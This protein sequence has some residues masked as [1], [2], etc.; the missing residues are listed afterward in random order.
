MGM[1][2]TEMGLKIQYERSSQGLITRREAKISIRD[3]KSLNF[4]EDDMLM[5]GDFDMNSM[6]RDTRSLKEVYK[7][8]ILNHEVVFRKQ[9]YELHRLYG[10]QKSLMRD[11]CWDEFNA[12]N[13]RTAPM[14]ILGP[15]TNQISYAPPAT[16]ETFSEIPMIGST[17]SR[18]NDCEEEPRVIFPRLQQRPMDLQL[19]AS[20]SVRGNNWGSLRNS[21]ELKHYLAG[22]NA[23][24]PEEVKLSLSIG[25]DSK[26]KND[27][28]TTWTD[29]IN[30]L[31]SQHIIDLEE[32]TETSSDED[33]IPVSTLDCAGPP[34]YSGDRHESQ[35]SV[36]SSPSFTNCMNDPSHGITIPHSF[37]DTSKGCQE[38]TFT[39]QGFNESVGHIP[40]NDMSAKGEVFVSYETARWDL[41]SI[42]PIELYSN[43]PVMACPSTGSSSC[44]ADELTGKFHDVK[45]SSGDNSSKTSTLLQQNVALM[46]CNSKNSNLN[47]WATNTTHEALI[48]NKASPIELENMSGPTSDLSE[49]PGNRSAFSKN[50]NLD[51]PLNFQHG[52]AIAVAM[53][54]VNCGNEN[55]NESL[56]LHQC[57]SQNTGED[58]LSSQSPGSCKLNIIHDENSSSMKAT[59]SGIDLGENSFPLNMS[60]SESSQ[61]VETPCNEGEHQCWDKKGES[62]EVDVLIQK[63][64][65]SLICMSL[66]SSTT[67]E[68]CITKTGSNEVENE[69]RD[70]PQNSLDSYE[71]LVLKLG[72]SSV[73]DCCVSSKALEFNEMDKN[74]CGIKLRRGR[75]LKDFQRDIL[76]VLSSL[77]RHEICEDINIFEGVMRSREYKKLRSRIANGANWFTPVKSK[78]SRLNYVG[79]KY[80]S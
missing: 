74:D 18:N 57:R 22:D 28:R 51:L 65:L 49:D 58:S 4:S 14:P 3:H 35:V 5:R 38:Q 17:Q 26:K 66:D 36:K 70:Q 19:S 75:R 41:N 10:V 62:A 33:A 45:G 80:Y 24:S 29:K 37:V 73:D 55:R 46:E 15:F 77:S 78:R 32:S 27:G 39:N 7:Q 8:T 67:N 72:E 79:R 42:Q 40:C 31:S 25:G 69:E 53:P 12:Y 76:P 68:D 30:Y 50:E 11:C 9:V 59:Q 44:D 16:E 6:Q 60:S 56:F 47:I 43:D 23:S 2:T 20:Y 34:T 71:S 1:P 61:V 54:G 64:A 21:A 48:G 13:F 52:N 63:A